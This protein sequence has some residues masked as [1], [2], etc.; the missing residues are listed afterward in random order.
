MAKY[1]ELLD[2]GI[3]MAARFHSHCPQTARMYY[4][5]PPLPPANKYHHHSGASGDVSAGVGNCVAKPGIGGVDT[6]DFILY[7]FV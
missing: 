3:R 5:P 2:A 7:S 4:H 6:A 1:A